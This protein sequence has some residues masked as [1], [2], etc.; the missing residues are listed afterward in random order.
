[1]APKTQMEQEASPN[2]RLR[3]SPTALLRIDSQQQEQLAALDREGIFSYEEDALQEEEWFRMEQPQSTAS[4]KKVSDEFGGL[5][6]EI[7]GI[8]CAACDDL[9]IQNFV[10]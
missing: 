1:M 9:H 10:G 7:K 4:M 2:K 5:P 8:E 6:Q 3:M